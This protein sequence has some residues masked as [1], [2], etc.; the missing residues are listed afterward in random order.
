MHAGLFRKSQTGS[1]ANRGGLDDLWLKALLLPLKI[2]LDLAVFDIYLNQRSLN[3]IQNFLNLFLLPQNG[4]TLNHFL[5]GHL[6][7][8]KIFETF[9]A[10]NL[11]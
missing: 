11:F 2:H 3:L 7:S 5:L 8:H 4:L 6:L 1:D 10:W 9:M